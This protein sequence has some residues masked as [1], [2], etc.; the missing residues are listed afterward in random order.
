MINIS[1]NLFTNA[2]FSG[3]T[4]SKKSSYVFAILFYLFLYNTIIHLIVPIIEDSTALF[5]SFSVQII[6]LFIF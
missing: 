3:A 4:V 1:Y 6:E 2:I 5:L